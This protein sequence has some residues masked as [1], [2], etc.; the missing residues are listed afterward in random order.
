[1]TQYAAD[2][3]L[4]KKC[5]AAMFSFDQNGTKKMDSKRKKCA[6]LLR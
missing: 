2:F 4:I 6:I 5:T 3:K 1:M